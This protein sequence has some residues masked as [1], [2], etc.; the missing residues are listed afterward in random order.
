MKKLTLN[1]ILSNVFYFFLFIN[2]FSCGS[3]S[4]SKSTFFQRIISAK[5][6]DVKN[7]T[8]CYKFAYSNGDN[9]EVSFGLYS[10]YNI[11]DTVCFEKQNDIVGWTSIVDCH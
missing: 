8:T 2:L 9:D 4:E 1:I 11:G 10:K 7:G 5:T 6:K 3:N